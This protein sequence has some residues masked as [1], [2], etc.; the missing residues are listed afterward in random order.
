MKNI[1]LEQLFYTVERLKYKLKRVEAKAS[2]PKCVTSVKQFE[3]RINLNPH[4]IADRSWI[5]TSI[6]YSVEKL[7]FSK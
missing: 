5:Q 2:I 3:Q 6:D 7:R 1:T 4:Q